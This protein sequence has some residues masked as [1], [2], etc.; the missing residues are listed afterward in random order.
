M[1]FATTSSSP[2]SSQARWQSP[3]GKFEDG[4][5]FCACSPPVQASFLQVK[6]AGNNK[7]RWFYTCPKPREEQCRFFIFEDAALVREKAV[8]DRERG[9]RAQVQ[10]Q[11]QEQAGVE[12]E[13]FS[14]LNQ[15]DNSLGAINSPSNN[16]S[17]RNGLGI[18]AFHQAATRSETPQS[19]VASTV[20]SRPLFSPA[21]SVFMTPGPR[22]GIFRG[23]PRAGNPSW[24]SDEEEDSDATA[25]GAGRRRNRYP[26][27]ATPTS[28]RKRSDIDVDDG[29]GVGPRGTRRGR[30]TAAAADLLPDLDSDDADQLV[31]MAD[32]T[33]RELHHQHQ[34]Q[35]SDPQRPTTPS[36]GRGGGGSRAGF[37]GLP[38]PESRNNRFLAVPGESGGPA[39]RFK[40]SSQGPA[41]PTPARTRNALLTAPGATESGLSQGDCCSPDDADITLAVL[42]LLKAE[43]VSTP[44]RRA[45]RETLNLHALRARGVER[46]R[47]VLREGLK[48]RDR[49]IAELQARVVRLENG[50][51]LSQEVLRGALEALVSQEGG[52]G[53]GK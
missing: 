16:P 13:V 12:V 10:E 46:G 22:H 9:K 4:T 25:D 19:E 26:A 29:V 37:G 8:L 5:W 40:S 7:G 30:T 33:E 34:S 47:D 2:P 31:E 20:A 3:P 43:P 45:L 6:K 39:K 23:I 53:G 17:A 41:T 52:E 42:G 18:G 49:K 51:S 50:R 27:V 21:S 28:K 14:R 36:A 24:S 48:T 44:V 32:Y 1:S 35:F 38:T 15:G 11:E